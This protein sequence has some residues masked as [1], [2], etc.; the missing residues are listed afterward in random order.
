MLCQVPCRQKI[1]FLRPSDDGGYPITSYTV[2]NAQTQSVAWTDTSYHSPVGS[3]ITSNEL[4]IDGLLRDITYGWVISASTVQGEGAKSSTQ[5]LQSLGYPDIRDLALGMEATQISDWFDNQGTASA[6][7]DG[8]TNGDAMTGKVAVTGTSNYAWWRVR[9]PA[10]RF[11]HKVR[12]YSCTSFPDPAIPAPG[13]G[14]NLKF[15]DFTIKT[16]NTDGN[17]TTGYSTQVDESVSKMKEFTPNPDKRPYAGS[18]GNELTIRSRVQF[19]FIAISEFRAFGWDIGCPNDYQCSNGGTCI[20]R[21]NGMDYRQCSCASGWA[22]L[23]CMIDISVE[24]AATLNP[25][26]AP[27]RPADGSGMYIVLLTLST[28]IM[29]LVWV[30][31]LSSMYLWHEFL[32]DEHAEAASAAVHPWAAQ[33]AEEVQTERNPYMAQQAVNQH[34]MKMGIGGSKAAQQARTKRPTRKASVARGMPSRKGS[35]KPQV[36]MPEGEG[37]PSNGFEEVSMF[38]AR[39]HD[40]EVHLRS[41]PCGMSLSLYRLVRER[42]KFIVALGAAMGLT[43]FISMVLAYVLNGASPVGR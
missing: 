33:P 28:V 8:D 13:W 26:S 24:A 7:L 19:A 30:C 5:T 36:W 18:R 9:M 39:A 29:V 38:G 17:G 3:S 40:E 14:C 22:G 41:P 31:G 11:I 35:V 10:E 27:N 20:E 6:A 12:L 43:F 37:G 25:T 32:R 16:R 15:Y 21:M 42:G 23:Q 1:F 4:I 34:R 2:Y